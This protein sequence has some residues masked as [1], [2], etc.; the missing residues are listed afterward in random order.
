MNIIRIIPNF[1]MNFDYIIYEKKENEEIE[2]KKTG[3]IKYQE[4]KDENFIK[5]F[6]NKYNINFYET[7]GIVFSDE[8]KKKLYE[9]FNLK[10]Y[11]VK[12][13]EE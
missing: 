8:D 13:K 3:T 11:T 5:D 6:K 12:T 9:K 10:E 7:T 2:I 1:T 4:L